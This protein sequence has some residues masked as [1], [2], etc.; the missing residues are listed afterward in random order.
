MNDLTTSHQEYF[1]NK[2]SDPE[3][4]AAYLNAMVEEVAEDNLSD[5]QTLILTALKNIIQAQ[6]GMQALAEKTGLNRQG[7][8]KIL[9]ANGNPRFTSLLD[10]LEFAGIS[11]EF[12]PKKTQSKKQA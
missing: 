4:A 11:I 7:L 8:Y 9:S 1:I 2:L 3:E 12:R 10:I 6:G 5:A